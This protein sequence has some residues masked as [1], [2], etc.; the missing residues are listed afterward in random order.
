MMAVKKIRPSFK[1]YEDDWKY[2]FMLICRSIGERKWIGTL[3][4]V[5]GEYVYKEEV[6][7]SLRL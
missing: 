7:S 1:K 5:N 2:M 3:E 6:M 4:K